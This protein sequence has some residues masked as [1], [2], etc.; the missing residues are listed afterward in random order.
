ME[1][2]LFKSIAAR[3][4]AAVDRE[5]LVETAVALVEVPSPTLQA[6]AAADRLAEVLSQAGFAV[7][8]PVANWPEAPAVAVRFETGRP[9]RALQFDGHLDTVHLPFV[10]PRVERGVLYGSGC[11]DMKG[12]IA[13]FVEAL[14]VLRDL[15]LLP[16]GG[17]LLTAHDHH[18]G[19]WGD[20]RQLLGLIEA[21]Y[22]GDAVLL[23]EYL[24]D[25][26]PV[27]GR[28]LAIFEVAV[29]REGE[30][31]H[32]VLRPADC[33]DVL[34]TG[35]DLV[36]RL[37][38]WNG[39]LGTTA[40]P[41]AGAESVFVGQ[42]A[43]GEVYNQVPTECRIQGTRRWVRPGGIEEVE[44]EFRRFVASA[45]SGSGASVSVD[46]SVQGDAFR[47][48]PEEPV[49]S[50]FQAAH[51][52]VAGAPL[53]PGGKP[54]LDDGN[55]FAARA[56]IPALTHGPDGKGAHTTEEQVAVDELV[57]VAEVYALT[58]VGFCGGERTGKAPGNEE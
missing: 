40:D 5:R 20:K 2:D 30:P 58:A 12:G 56:G 8:R 21:G 50:A 4:R 22:A 6:K 38:E 25:R 10:P 47:L 9:G 45:A 57:R 41:H 46:F 13:S 15:E 54:F 23:P 3:V 16:G 24:A 27:A 51:A 48:A 11:A 17:V 53:P 44:A 1:A 36:C 37:R 14:R 35:A 39:R 42:I 18:E 31:V 49:V 52:A 7:E 34:G 55:L 19:P 28:G 33:P 43:S 26:L 32:E 29:C